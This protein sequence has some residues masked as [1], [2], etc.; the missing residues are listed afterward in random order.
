MSCLAGVDL[1]RLSFAIKLALS[2]KMKIGSILA[3]VHIVSFPRQSEE[4]WYG[5]CGMV[6]VKY[7]T[8]DAPSP[9]DNLSSKRF[10]FYH[11]TTYGV[12]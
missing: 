12:W 4:E 1:L 11:D 6:P 3:F 2:R 10:G 8:D 5:R 7:M 9:I